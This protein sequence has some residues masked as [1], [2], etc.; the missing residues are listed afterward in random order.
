MA[1]VEG[2]VMGPDVNDLSHASLESTCISVKHFLL[3][4]CMSCLMER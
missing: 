4:Q 1:A 2:G 3:G